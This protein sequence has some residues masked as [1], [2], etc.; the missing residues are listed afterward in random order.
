[1]LFINKI[2]A[3]GVVAAAADRGK[4]I[5][6]SIAL[7]WIAQHPVESSEDVRKVDGNDYTD[8]ADDDYEDPYSEFVVSDSGLHGYIEQNLEEEELEIICRKC[9]APLTKKMTHKHPPVSG[10]FSQ[11]SS[12]FLGIDE[13]LGKDIGMVVEKY[14]NPQGQNFKLSTFPHL[15]PSNGDY[16]KTKGLAY[17][18]ASFYPPYNWKVAVCPRCGHQV[19]WHFSLSPGKEKKE[20]SSAAKAPVERALASLKN[21]CKDF[22]KGYWTYRWCHRRHIH[23]FHLAPKPSGDSIPE[24]K[25]LLGEYDDARS[26][27][28]VEYF[29]GGRIC[30]ETN[31]RRSTRVEFACCGDKSVFI[32]SVEEIK[33]CKYLIKVCVPD[34]CS[35]RDPTPSSSAQQSKKETAEAFWALDHDQVLVESAG[36][37]EWVD[38]IKIMPIT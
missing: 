30:D 14:K 29:S 38:S 35:I 22:N 21:V 23:Q 8:G 34:L 16:I 20:K 6:L 12:G 37:L 10:G 5:L 2:I 4:L 33:L 11:T 28:A 18:E 25:W 13:E 1:M 31:E 24:A 3:M 15:S 9:G 17:G 27:G 32:G 36:E 26:S 19:G 7:A